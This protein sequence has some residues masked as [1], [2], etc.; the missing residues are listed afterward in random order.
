MKILNE[1][2]KYKENKNK[3]LP[4]QQAEIEKLEDF[5]ARNKARVATRGM[6]NSRQKQ[7]DKM[8]ILEKPQQKIRPEFNFLMARTPSRFIVEAKDL[9]IGYDAPLTKPVSFTVERGRKNCNHR[10]Q[11]TG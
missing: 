1:C 5:I 7:L 3:S 8:E 6:A 9:V 10:D 4:K 2:M 11:R